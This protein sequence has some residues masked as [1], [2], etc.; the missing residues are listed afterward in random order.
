MCLQQDILDR[1]ATTEFSEYQKVAVYLPDLVKEQDVQGMHVCLAFAVA[2][3]YDYHFVFVV[4]PGGKGGLELLEVLHLEEA[5]VQIAL[6]PKHPARLFHRIKVT[7]LLV[8]HLVDIGKV[9]I[10]QETQYVKGFVETDN[11]RR[12]QGGTRPQ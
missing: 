6:A 10:S 2:D 3:D 12:D 4:I 5:A 1:F 8:P 11:G 7:R 9:S